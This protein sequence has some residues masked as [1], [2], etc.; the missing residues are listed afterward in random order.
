MRLVPCRTSGIAHAGAHRR[1]RSRHCLCPEAAGRDGS[2]SV[3][4]VAASHQMQPRGRLAGSWPVLSDCGSPRQQRGSRR[5]GCF[6][7]RPAT[8]STAPRDR[9]RGVA[10]VPLRPSDDSCWAKAVTR[11]LCADECVRRQSASAR[12]T[13]GCLSL[14]AGSRRTCSVR[15][16]VGA[17]A[18]QG[19]AG[20]SASAPS[21][22]VDRDLYLLS[23]PT[24]QAP[25]GICYIFGALMFTATGC[26]PGCAPTAPAQTTSGSSKRSGSAT[27]ARQQIYWIQDNL[28]ANWTPCIR[29]S[30]PTTRLEC[31]RGRGHLIAWVCPTRLEGCGVHAKDASAVSRGVPS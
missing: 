29:P 21:E 18:E 27:P 9:N 11:C 15:W 10:V 24:E 14:A 16:S 26:T 22:P 23:V 17:L 25:D 4:V 6:G 28:S 7:S 2:V 12:L 8:S 1:K 31:P 13:V 3:D 20:T 30:L 19:S 5:R